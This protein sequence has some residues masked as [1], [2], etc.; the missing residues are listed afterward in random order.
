MTNKTKL[1]ILTVFF[2]IATLILTASV[3]AANEGVQI[4]QKALKAVE[5]ILLDHIIVTASDF[6][7]FKDSGLI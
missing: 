7:S 5:V 6:Y 4:L 3:Y 2:V 1:I